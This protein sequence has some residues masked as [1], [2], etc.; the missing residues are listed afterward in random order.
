MNELEKAIEKIQKSIER[1]NK[2]NS[3]G[4]RRYTN[5]NKKDILEFI[6][7]ALAIWYKNWIYPWG[8]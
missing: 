7:Q 8:E 6:Q 1:N 5:K 4:R 3:T 2:N